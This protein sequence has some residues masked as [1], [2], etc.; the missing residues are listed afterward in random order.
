M[1]S[2]DTLTKSKLLKNVYFLLVD[3]KET[4]YDTVPHPLRRYLGDVT[5]FVY[6]LVSFCCV[7]WCSLLLV[8]V[9]WQVIEVE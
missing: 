1:T 8:V 6:P 9:V 5:H 3:I 4:V 2:S 7:V